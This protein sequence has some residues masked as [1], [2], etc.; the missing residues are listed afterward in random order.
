MG[1]G[2]PNVLFQKCGE[3][4]SKI[5]NFLGGIP[6]MQTEPVLKPKLGDILK[7]VLPGGGDLT[8]RVWAYIRAKVHAMQKWNSKGIFRT[9][10][11]EA[12]IKQLE[13]FA[14]AEIKIFEHAW[15]IVTER[16]ALQVKCEIF[17]LIDA[18]EKRKE[19]HDRR[20]KQVDKRHREQSNARREQESKTSI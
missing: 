4:A 16:E 19:I 10:A 6:C 7:L 9:A 20:L 5:K 11:V 3:D 17:F 1:Q 14:Y 18:V 2:G 13:Q 12:V 15:L 8:T